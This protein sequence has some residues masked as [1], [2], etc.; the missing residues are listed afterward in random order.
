MWRRPRRYPAVSA[1]KS[2]VGGPTLPVMAQR[3]AVTILVLIAAWLVVGAVL[4]FVFSLVRGL[5][6]VVLFAIIAWVVLVGP[7]G[8][9]Q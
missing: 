6:F 3:I 4:G 8:R 9:D 5:L 7:P 1:A 2:S